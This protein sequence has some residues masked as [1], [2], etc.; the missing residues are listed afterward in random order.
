MIKLIRIFFSYI[1][2]FVSTSVFAQSYENVAVLKEKLDGSFYQTGD[3]GHV[4]FEFHEKY[5]DGSLNFKVYNSLREDITP[6]SNNLVSGNTDDKEYGMNIYDLNL[7][8]N[9]DF[10]YD[11]Y[12]YL[13][14]I[15][16]KGKLLK[17]RFRFK[18]NE[19]AGQ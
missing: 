2:L 8:A 18:G 5:Q 9:E 15:D 17:L 6:T 16:S 11:E 3:D 14:V 10:D 19:G 12:Y 1:L 13:E 7:D 4:Y